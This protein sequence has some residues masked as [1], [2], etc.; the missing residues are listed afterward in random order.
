MKTT[1][2]EQAIA[3]EDAGARRISDVAPRKIARED[4][5]A[6]CVREE[7]LRTAAACEDDRIR[8]ICDVTLKENLNIY[9]TNIFGSTTNL[10]DECVFNHLEVKNHKDKSPNFLE[11][12]KSVRNAMLWYIQKEQSGNKKRSFRNFGTTF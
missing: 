3:C 2:E 8:R 11:F 5:R 7:A 4:G 6:S 12:E 1:E 9:E 10:V